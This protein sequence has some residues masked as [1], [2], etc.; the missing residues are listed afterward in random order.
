MASRAQAK[1]KRVASIRSDAY[2][3][4]VLREQHKKRR[5]ALLRFLLHSENSLTK[6]KAALLVP[7]SPK[8][9]ETIE[10]SGYESTPASPCFGAAAAQDGN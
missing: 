10:G 4:P 1:A 8:S 9:S 5:P 2:A 3:V 7:D 6:P